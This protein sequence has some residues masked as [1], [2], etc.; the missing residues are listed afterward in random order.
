MNILIAVPADILLTYFRA[1]LGILIPRSR[2]YIRGPAGGN[3]V[4]P[5]IK[6]YY[7][8]AG[9]F[10][11]IGIWAVY[12]YWLWAEPGPIRGSI[13]SYYNSFS[14]LYIFW[15]PGNWPESQTGRGRKSR[16]LRILIR[17]ERNGNLDGRVENMKN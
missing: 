3:L 9:P 11:Y 2:K 4:R 10:T 16:I 17:I 5:N 12:F 8:G 14:G 6:A 13:K 1:T 7:F 15:L